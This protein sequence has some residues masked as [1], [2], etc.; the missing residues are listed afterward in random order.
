MSTDLLYKPGDF[1][2]YRFCGGVGYAYLNA[3]KWYIPKTYKNH[4]DE[5]VSPDPKIV[6]LATKFY[7]LNSSY[8]MYQSY[9][10]RENGWKNQEEYYATHPEYRRDHW[11]E[12]K[13]PNYEQHTKYFLPVW[14]DDI[15]FV[16]DFDKDENEYPTQ[17][18][19]YQTQKWENTIASVHNKFKWFDK[20]KLIKALDV[21]YSTFT[22]DKQIAAQAIEKF[23]K[24][25]AQVLLRK[26][27]A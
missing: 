24:R 21:K 7:G 17:R 18:Y 8:G 13:Q 6:Y 9:G 15:C 11:P 1:V 14:Q 25:K 20:E 5:I 2:G 4:N 16:V 26:L 22:G 27:T 23:E 3:Y 19:N 10:F 12:G